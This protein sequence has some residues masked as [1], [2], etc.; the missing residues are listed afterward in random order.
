ME[1]YRKKL[2]TRIIG[3]SC[4]SVVALMIVVICAVLATR[5]NTDRHINDAALG[6]QCG[7][8]ASSAVLLIR[9]IV[10]S[11]RA[12]KYDAKCKALYIKEHDEREQAIAMKAGQ[13]AYA[14]SLPLIIVAVIVAGFFNEIVF[15]TLTAVIFVVSVIGGACL[16]FYQKRL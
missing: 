13:S 1:A 16:L 8:F 10:I 15:W 14:C 2:K 7:L 3:M 11:V 6:F 12:L 5:T 9:R 4:F